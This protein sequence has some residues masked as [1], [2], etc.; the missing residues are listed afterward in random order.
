MFVY[1]YCKNILGYD[2]PDYKESTQMMLTPILTPATVPTHNQFE[3]EMIDLNERVRNYSRVR[4]NLDTDPDL[5]YTRMNTSSNTDLNTSVTEREPVIR[6][7][8]KITFSSEVDMNKKKDI[9]T[10]TILRDRYHHFVR[11]RCYE[12]KLKHVHKL[13]IR[14]QNPPEDMT[15]NIVKYIIRNY[16]ND[17][18]CRWSKCLGEKG[19]LTSRKHVQPEVKAFTS[20]G[21]I[22][23]SP[24]AKFSVLYLL[25]LRQMFTHDLI[26]LWKVNLHSDSDEFKN[27]KMNK[28][29]TLNVQRLSGRRPRITWNA[30]HKQI[31]KHCK[32]VYSGSFDNIFNVN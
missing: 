15:E 5:D 26:T 11:S 28:D 20:D 16:D 8:P 9:Y 6:P 1:R 25:D 27:I 18:T 14:Y 19:D 7:T 31:G 24:S 21:P 10:E 13:N 30:L 17:Q 29:E 2:K 3:K 22:Q 12:H 4:Y 23:F 32:I